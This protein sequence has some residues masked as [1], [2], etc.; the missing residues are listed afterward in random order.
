MQARYASKEAVEKEAGLPGHRKRI[1]VLE[2]C[3]ELVSWET[4]KRWRT[5]YPTCK[6]FGFLRFLVND[7]Q[8]PMD[9]TYVLLFKIVSVTWSRQSYAAPITEEKMSHHGQVLFSLTVYF[10]RENELFGKITICQSRWYG[11]NEK[12]RSIR[13]RGQCQKKTERQKK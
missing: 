1:I 8:K 3:K 4:I 6:V 10:T 7:T 12:D 5:F 11:N 2:G 13:K 9:V